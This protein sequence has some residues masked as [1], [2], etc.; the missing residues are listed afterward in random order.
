MNQSLSDIVGDLLIVPQ[1]TLA[2]DASKGLRA[3]FD[4]A[5]APALGACRT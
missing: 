5:V 1:F 3:S 4:G 2:A